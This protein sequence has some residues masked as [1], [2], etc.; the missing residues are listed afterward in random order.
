MALGDLR[1]MEGTTA[2]WAPFSSVMSGFPVI[3]SAVLAA[4]AT[5]VDVA[6]MKFASY[7]TYEDGSLGIN[8]GY[9]LG[10]VAKIEDYR[11]DLD[12]GAASGGVVV[13][14]VG[15]ADTPTRET[16]TQ[17]INLA[18]K[19]GFGVGF[20]G[21][22]PIVLDLD[23]DGYELTTQRNSG[24]YFEFDGDGYA[25]KT[26]WVRPDDGFLV[27]DANA[28]GIVEDASEFFGDETQGGFAELATRGCHVTSISE[29]VGV[30]SRV[31]ANDNGKW[32]ELEIA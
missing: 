13:F 10:G 3:G 1:L 30:A 32:H 21:W 16:F 12:S 11:L 26:G 14:E 19:A 23:G 24:V 27:L 17:F 31:A 2:Y 20:A 18:L 22:D 5:F 25:E 9:G 4:A 29:A 8:I 6:T 28:N 15:H 7:Q